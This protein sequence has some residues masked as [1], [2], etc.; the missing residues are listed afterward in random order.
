MCQVALWFGGL[1]GTE[2]AGP[3]GSL[4]QHGGAKAPWVSKHVAVSGGKGAVEKEARQGQRRQR[5]SSCGGRA[6]RACEELFGL[7]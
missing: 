2:E 3:G 7:H 1:Q 4:V 5:W 6:A